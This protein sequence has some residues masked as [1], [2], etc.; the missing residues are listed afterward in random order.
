[1]IAVRP[2][3][4]QEW[5][6]YKA[7]RLGAL[8]D[9]PDAF[10]STYEAEAARADEFWIERMKAA[11]NSDTNYVLFAEKDGVPCGLIW[12]VLSSTDAQTADIYQMW[13]APQ[14]RGLRAGYLLL[15]DAVK[16]AE[17]K[18]VRQLHLGVTKTNTAAIALYEKFGFQACGELEPLRDDSPL[19]VQG[20]TLG[21]GV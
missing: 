3:H 5:R 1:M 13:V 18:G 4:A 2:V 21:I 8:Q 14:S 16:W 12:C 15:D 20:M 17:Q 9:S 11:A 6:R 10:G 7:L 19:M